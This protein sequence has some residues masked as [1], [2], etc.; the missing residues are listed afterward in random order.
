MNDPVLNE[1]LKLATLERIAGYTVGI[2]VNENTGVGTGTL[3]TDGKDRLILTAAHVIEG[4]E[5]SGTRFWL[6][7]NA[8]MIEKAAILTTDKEVG[9][10]TAGATIPIVETRIDSKT[11]IAILRIDDSFVLPEG[12]EVYPLNRSFEFAS[13]PD[14]ALDGISTLIF[15][16]PTANSRP[17]RTIGNNTT[18]F[19]GLAS[20]FSRYS[21]ALN[22]DGFRKLP[23]DEVSSEKDFLLDYTGIG[24]DGAGNDMDPHGFSGCGA[25]VSA[26]TEGTLLWKSDPILI[27]VVHRYFR[28]S[29]VLAATK[30]PS[31]VTITPP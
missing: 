8:A 4:T 31:I 28:K 10:M 26:D 15:G 5:M 13:W 29:N 23:Y 11:D 22:I 14:T 12:P 30:L 7:P 18:C 20:M 25:W 19:L 27:G 24:R 6:R 1:Q 3:V 9:R 21:T 2:A 16:F 17:I